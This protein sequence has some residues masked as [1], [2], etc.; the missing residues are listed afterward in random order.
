MREISVDLPAL[1]NPTRP[2]SAS[3][4]RCS[5][6]CLRF[7]GHARFAAPRC[8]IG[9][10]GEA[11]VA[12]PADAALRDQHPLAGLDEIADERR[13]LRRIVRLLEDERA[14]GH[15]E[16]DV[17]GVLAGAVGA[18]P[19]AAAL[20]VELAVEAEGDERVDVG[21]GDGI[22]GTALASV[23][24]VGAAAG[25]ELLAP[26]AHAAGAAVAGFYEDVDFVDEHVVS[27][28]SSIDSRQSQS[29]VDRRLLD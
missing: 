28:E 9:R 13:R 2:T 7:A 27:R 8:A 25:N 18:L 26:E 22:H 3:S 6:S 29:T 16:L 10:A 12:A 19:V 23:P 5:W 1:G 20:G 15:F 4:F 24:A 11:R 14:D 21:A 17:G